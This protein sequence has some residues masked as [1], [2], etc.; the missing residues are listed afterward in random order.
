MA[1]CTSIPEMDMYMRMYIADVGIAGDD[2]DDRVVRMD[3]TAF[4][5]VPV[6]NVV[7]YK[8]KGGDQFHFEFPATPQFRLFGCSTIASKHDSVA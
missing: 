2:S 8:P 3:L 5:A 4:D 1:T 7:E 6:S